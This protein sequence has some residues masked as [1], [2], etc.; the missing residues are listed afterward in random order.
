[1]RKLFAAAVLI[2][3]VPFTAWAAVI[4][5]PLDQPTIQSGIDVAYVGDTVLVADGTYTGDG[6]RDISFNGKA[7]TVMSE[8]GAEHCVI[9]SG[10]S[11][12]EN[13]RG[14][15]LHNGEGNLS[16]IQGFKIQNG[17][18]SPPGT[19]QAGGGIYCD[20]ASPTIQNCIITQNKAYYGG[21]IF[22]DHSSPIIIDCI[23]SG[24]IADIDGSANSIGG[25]INIYSGSP[26]LTNCTITGNSA[27]RGGGISFYN[28]SISSVTNCTITENNGYDGGG[29]FLVNS[30]PDITDCVISENR[31]D[32]GG[33]ILCEESSLTLRNCSFTRNSAVNGGGIYTYDGSPIIGGSPGY[34]NYFEGNQAA[35]GAD[36]ASEGPLSPQVNATNNIFAGNHLS[37][38]YVSPNES[39][40]LDSCS[41]EITPLTQDVYV[42][43]TGSDSNDGLTSATAFLTLQHAMSVVHGTETDPVTV[44]IAEGIYS[45]SITGESY[46][47]PFLENVSIIGENETATQLNA[48]GSSCIFYG[49][50]DDDV[51]VSDLTITQGSYSSGGGMYIWYSSPTVIRCT[52]TAN[53]ADDYGGGMYGYYSDPIFADCTYKGNTSVWDGGAMY[54][55]SSTPSISSCIFTGNTARHGGGV[56]GWKSTVILSHSRFTGNAVEGFGGGIRFEDDYDSSVTNCTVTNNSGYKGAGLSC[57]YFASPIITDCAVTGNEGGGIHCEYDCSPIITNCTLSGNTGPGITCKRDS[58]AMIDSCIIV[59]N[60]AINGAGIFCDDSSPFFTNCIVSGNVANGIGGGIYCKI[61]ESSPEIINCL[62]SG[63]LAVNAGGGIYVE[64]NPSLRLTNCTITGNV[65]ELYGGGIYCSE[66]PEIT[67]CIFWNDTPDEFYISQNNPTVTYSCIQD[68]F[69]GVGNIDTDPLFI[70]GP[71]GEYYLTQVSAGQTQDSPCVNSGSDVAENVCFEIPGG[72]VCLNAFWTRTDGV[73]DSGQVDMGM[74]YPVPVHLPPPPVVE[75]TMPS[76]HFYPGDS[77]SCD[78]NVSNPGDTSIQGYPLFVILGVSGTYFFAPSFNTFDFYSQSFTAGDTTVEVVPEFSWPSGAGSANGILWYSALTNPEMN[79][80]YSNLAIF[81][82]GWSE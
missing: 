32:Y 34:G 68:G 72:D 28:T 76:S 77:C 73:Q 6:N 20:Q 22:S 71:L 78:A 12:E 39:F 37:D 66:G 43:T 46:P 69:E 17:Y 27:G 42:S 5:V 63:N 50:Y 40:N 59:E 9:D 80:L 41:S 65:S 15:Y 48:E 82:F 14:F 51:H 21:G 8:H 58:N 64:N 57:K 38:Y 62:I 30:S 16:V 11:E 23:I 31:A 70:S 55:R 36:L 79:Q 54:F 61:Q 7:I 74:H 53:S 67:N 75:I 29:L 35:A 33:G 18:K 26:T 24:N 44:H 13:H 56:F 2:F 25:G 10:G 52:F 60:T 1:M 19:D 4:H 47:L 45:P 49:Y 3:V 81:E